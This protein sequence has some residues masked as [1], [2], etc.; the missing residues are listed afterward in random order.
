[1][2]LHWWTRLYRFRRTTELLYHGEDSRAS[3][4]PNALSGPQAGQLQ[5]WNCSS[6]LLLC[7]A[8]TKDCMR[9][10]AVY[11]LCKTIC[12]CLS[13]C[14]GICR[15]LCKHSFPSSLCD[16]WQALVKRYRGRKRS[17]GVSLT[18]GLGLGTL[19]PSGF[20]HL[21][22]VFLV[23]VRNCVWKPLFTVKAQLPKCIQ[24]YLNK[25]VTVFKH[26]VH[27]W[28]NRIKSKRNLERK[29]A[30]PTVLCPFELL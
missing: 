23:Q 18:P 29:L 4:A 6:D 9:D 22:M 1:M 27:P 2:T 17:S 8:P 10:P 3:E 14:D 26:L 19:E 12:C 5:S 25:C 30:R 16:Q 15:V 24:V 13:C 21:H 28:E 11:H 20:P 7:S